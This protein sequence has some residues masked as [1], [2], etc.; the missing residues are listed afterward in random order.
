MYGLFAIFRWIFNA[1]AIFILALIGTWLLLPDESVKPEVEALFST[2]DVPPSEENGYFFLWG[3]NASPELDP[4]AVGQQIVTRH[5]EVVKAKVGL[6]DFTPEQFLGSAPLPLP[7][8]TARCNSM[9]E[10]CLRFYQN[11]AQKA[12]ADVE[13]YASYIKRYRELRR[14]PRFSERVMSPVLE[15]PLPDCPLAVAMSE[16]VDAEI[17]LNLA[18]ISTRKHAL[19]ELAAELA[20]WRR[21]VAQ[22]DMLITQMVAVAV[23]QR[24]YKLSSEIMQAYPEIVK[25]Y[26]ATFKEITRPMSIEEAN[27]QRTL[28]SEFRFSAT[29]ITSMSL[30]RDNQ[31]GEKS[32][33]DK[34]REP[35]LRPAY[36]SNA[37]INLLHAQYQ[38]NA[39]FLTKKPRE[40]YARHA[41]YVAAQADMNPWHPKVLFYNP[42]GKVLVGISFPDYSSYAFRLYDLVGYSRLVDIQ[43]RIVEEEISRDRLTAFIRQLDATLF[44]P[45]TDQPMRVDLTLRTIS[46]EGHGK[47]AEENGMQVEL[48]RMADS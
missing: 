34:L 42:L 41:E 17:V 28:A 13:R 25:Q 3:L 10:N 31:D 43:R 23:L 15:S 19:D 16:L 35:V 7:V 44:N 46:F 4:H 48:H 38:K 40:L 24:K 32:L 12:R 45:Y 14:Y 37:T 26:A 11:N 27:L 33:L 9:A 20:T 29:V 30:H 8:F 47:W 22:S 6:G 5:E 1:V 21:I 2:P 39:E 18:S 36:E